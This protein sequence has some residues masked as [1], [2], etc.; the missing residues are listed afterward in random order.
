M[1][2]SA[3]KPRAKSQEPSL[4]L[5]IPT[6]AAERAERAE[7]IRLV[8]HQNMTLLVLGHVPSSRESVMGMISMIG[9]IGE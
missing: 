1:S 4:E 5:L 8:L 7:L 9:T 3:D 2:A 6:G